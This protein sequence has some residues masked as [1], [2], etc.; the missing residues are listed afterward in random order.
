M[1][2]A[3]IA[4]YLLAGGRRSRHSP[5]SEAGDARNRRAIGAALIALVVAYLVVRAL[6]IP[7]Q[8]PRTP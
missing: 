5:R 3:F 6:G 4:T 8:G 2:G 7:L 1:A